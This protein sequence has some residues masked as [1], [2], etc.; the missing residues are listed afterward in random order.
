MSVKV[1]LNPHWKILHV[2]FKSAL[3]FFFINYAVI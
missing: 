2:N 3:A 1:D